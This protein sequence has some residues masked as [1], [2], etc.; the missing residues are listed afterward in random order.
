[1]IGVYWGRFNPPHKGHLRVIKGI[2][3]EVDKLFVVVGSAEFRNTKR[4]PFDGTEKRKM[5][6][7]YLKEEG[8]DSNKVK[9]VVVMDGK[10]YSVGIQNLF[11][12]CGQFDVLYTDKETVIKLIRK[13]VRIKRIKRA[14]TISSTKIRDAIAFNQSWEQFTGKSVARLIKKFNGIKRI[15]EAYGIRG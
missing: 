9:V 1:M 2:L 4:N 11:E 8:I 5:M 3:K 6:Q 13:K 12:C 7:A 15:K 10:S 14:G